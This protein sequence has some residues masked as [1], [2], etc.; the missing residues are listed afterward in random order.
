MDYVLEI[1]GTNPV[2]LGQFSSLITGLELD[3]QYYFRGYAQNLGGEVRS[4][5][6]ETFIA[7]DT[8]FTKYT[9]EGMVLWLMHRMWMVMDILIISRKVHLYRFG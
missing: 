8:T 3:K 4:P 7:M 5:N 1:N 6:T 9:M 2:G